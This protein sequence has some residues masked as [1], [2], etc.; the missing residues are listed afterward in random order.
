MTLN[1]LQ[2]E[3]M[4]TSDVTHNQLNHNRDPDVWLSMA[5]FAPREHQ[6]KSREVLLIKKVNINYQT[7]RFHKQTKVYST[8]VYIFDINKRNQL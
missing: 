1:G 7:Y 6:R 8:K 2:M 5:T 3:L 4:Q